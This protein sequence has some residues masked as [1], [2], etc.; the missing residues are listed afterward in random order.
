M[1]ARPIR[2]SSIDFIVASSKFL[3]P[4]VLVLLLA[5]VP[6]VGARFPDYLPGYLIQI[7]AIGFGF[8]CFR[9]FRL[10]DKYRLWSERL[11]LVLS[12]L[13]PL[14]NTFLVKAYRKVLLD[15]HVLL[16]IFRPDILML[17]GLTFWLVHQRKAVALPVILVLSFS[18]GLV[19][20]VLSSLFS[21]YPILSFGNGIF[22]FF[23]VWVVLYAFLAVAPDRRFMVHAAALFCSGA[24]LAAFAQT[25]TIWSGIP[26]DTVFGIPIF[27]EELLNVKKDL[28][29]MVKAGGNGYGNTDNFA[30]LWVLLVPLVAGLFY[31][32]RR[33]GILSI[34]LVL[35]CYAG[36]LVYSRSSIVIVIFALICLWCYRFIAYRSIS[37]ALLVVL[38]GLILIHARPEIARYYTSGIASF[39]QGLVR[40]S[41]P[42]ERLS[43]RAGSQTKILD[44]SAV[45]RA[46][47]WRRG[48]AIATAHW[49]TGIGFGAYPLVEP[50]Y[51][52]PHSMALLRFAEGGVL[53]L[54]SFL[55]LCV[56]APLRFLKLRKIED[57]LAAACLISL[58]AFFIKVA[59]FGGSFSINGQIVWGFGVALAVAISLSPRNEAQK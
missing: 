54:M 24:G 18:L 17:A 8:L 47:A 2:Y 9:Y 57:V 14:Q 39:A 37:L 45:A 5:G 41:E 23:A 49:T 19:G 12:F 50:E 29:L 44:A 40:R 3:V 6:F 32:V 55:L 26:S 10:M 38:A 35:L 56:Y 34:F 59:I 21:D 31:L 15:E 20:W 42:A 7:P 4:L 53:S 1:T 11:L 51:T 58:S 28:E 52:A 25:A 43:W 30:S 48:V 27:A 46:D 36:L 16:E 22:E 13:I 33:D